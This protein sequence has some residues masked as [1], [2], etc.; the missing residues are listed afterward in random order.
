MRTDSKTH[1]DSEYHIGA[2]LDRE[3]WKKHCFHHRPC[4][5]WGCLLAKAL[6]GELA[7]W[8]GMTFSGWSWRLDSISVPNTPPPPNSQ[9]HP[10]PK[11]LLCQGEAEITENKAARLGNWWRNQQ[12]PLCI[13]LRRSSDFRNSMLRTPAAESPVWGEVLTGLS[14]VGLGVFGLASGSDLLEWGQSTA[15]HWALLPVSVSLSI[16]APVLLKP[17]TI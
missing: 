11:D 10:I 13:G 8:V 14:H 16:S 15:E 6:A 7:S 9:V 17:R 1:N 5:S 2:F 12:S 4:C 3:G